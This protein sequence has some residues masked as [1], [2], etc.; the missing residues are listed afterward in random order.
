VRDGIF[1]DLPMPRAWRSL[2]RAAVRPA[3]RGDTARR[4]AEKAL[5][6]DINQELPSVTRLLDQMV[7]NGQG[8]LPGFEA[9]AALIH[10]PGAHPSPMEQ[11]IVAAGRRLESEGVRGSALKQQALHE[12]MS[13]WAERRLRHIEQ[14]GLVKSGTEAWPALRAARVAVMSVLPEVTQRLLSGTA[15][16]GSAARRPVDLDEDLTNLP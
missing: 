5:T 8:T 16:T 7:G 3:E 4:F 9:P 2:M 13:D 12:A 1:K 10:I 6:R 14:H 11:S 15:G